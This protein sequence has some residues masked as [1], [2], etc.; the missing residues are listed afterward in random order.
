MSREDRRRVL[1]RAL[2][3]VGDAER[4]ARLL[5]VRPVQINNWLADFSELPD[6]YFLKLVDLCLDHDAPSLWDDTS[7]RNLPSKVR[8]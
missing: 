8:E 4:L 6:E 1:S 2:E 5:G 7:S 3:I